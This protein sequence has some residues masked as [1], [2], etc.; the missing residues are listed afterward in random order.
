VPT[1]VLTWSRRGRSYWLLAALI[2]AVLA[3]CGFAV[4]GIYYATLP[5]V[6]CLGR[7]M[8]G[9][10]EECAETG[11]PTVFN[12][13]QEAVPEEAE[14]PAMV[15]TDPL[16]FALPTA[17]D[18]G[19]GPRP[20]TGSFEVTQATWVNVDVAPDGTAVVFDVLG[21]L[22]RLPIAGGRTC[23]GRDST[24]HSVAL[25]RQDGQRP[26]CCGAGLRSTRS[27]GM[28]RMASRCSFA[29]TSPVRWIRC[30]PSAS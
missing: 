1:R 13:R 26:S 23:T 12:T 5:A 10:A 9:V 16:P 2:L 21:G 18:I 15:E 24:P 27:R 20:N 29:R 28:R 30:P 11:P 6:R 25:T 14:P 4:M 17:W 8:Q 3:A 7:G 22:Y 19:A